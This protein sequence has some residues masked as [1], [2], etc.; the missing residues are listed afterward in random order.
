MVLWGKKHS[1]MKKLWY[2]GKH[3]GNKPKQLKFL[4]KYVALELDK[5]WKNYGSMEKKHDSMEKIMILWRKL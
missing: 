4:K 2:Y 1:T 5:L 3:Y